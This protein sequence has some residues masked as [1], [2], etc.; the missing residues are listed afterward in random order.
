[1]HKV[2]VAVELLTVLPEKEEEKVGPI[3]MLFLPQ[4][5]SRDE[6]R[7]VILLSCSVCPRFD[8]G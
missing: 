4:K 8:M 2:V 6:V 1:M 3:H 7:R 5:T